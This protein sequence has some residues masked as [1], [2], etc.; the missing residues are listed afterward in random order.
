[1]PATQIPSCCPCPGVD[2]GED[3]PQETLIG[4]YERIQQQERKTNEDHM[5]QLP[6]EGE[7]ADRG[8]EAHT[9]LALRHGAACPSFWPLAGRADGGLPG[10]QSSACRLEESWLF[11]RVALEALRSLVMAQL[12]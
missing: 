3:I 2:N 12:C 9:C 4:L 11:A 6:P 7:E 8:E 1:M 10:T 5:S